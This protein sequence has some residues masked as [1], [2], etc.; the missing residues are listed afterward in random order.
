MKD[1]K[2]GALVRYGSQLFIVIKTDRKHPDYVEV[3]NVETLK[4]SLLP[5]D[6]LLKV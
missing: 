2:V 3:R 5:R 4:I 6:F 1:F